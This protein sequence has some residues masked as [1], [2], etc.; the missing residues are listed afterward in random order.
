MVN[1]TCSGRTQGDAPQT[2]GV[3]FRRF[4]SALPYASVTES[5]AVFH[6]NPV[7]PD[8]PPISPATQ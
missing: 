4:G 3:P 5:T 7:G 6:L 8:V 2:R 1:A